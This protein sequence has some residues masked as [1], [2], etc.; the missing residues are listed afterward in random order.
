MVKIHGTASR[1]V[2]QLWFG[3]ASQSGSFVVVWGVSHEALPWDNSSFME[4]SIGK[5]NSMGFFITWCGTQCRNGGDSNPPIFFRWKPSRSSPATL[6]LLWCFWAPRWTLL[7]G[8]YSN[9]QQKTNDLRRLADSILVHFWFECL[10]IFLGSCRAHSWNKKPTRARNVHA[11]V[12][13]S[14]SDLEIRLG[15]FLGYIIH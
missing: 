1:Q 14:G 5:S 6:L 15:F 9:S 10:V 7:C 11:A 4:V 12:D 2:Q 13:F 3:L 8:N